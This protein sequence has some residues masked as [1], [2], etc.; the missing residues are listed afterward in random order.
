MGSVSG[1]LQY[2]ANVVRGI[3]PESGFYVVESGEEYKEERPQVSRVFKLFS[4][5]C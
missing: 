5:L 2:H 3:Y 1:L 4:P